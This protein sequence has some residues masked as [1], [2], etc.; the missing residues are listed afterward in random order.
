M[1][2]NHMEQTNYQTQEPTSQRLQKYSNDDAIRNR[3]FQN[4]CPRDPCEEHL[5]GASQFF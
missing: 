5:T 2:D 3:V 1:Q 4:R